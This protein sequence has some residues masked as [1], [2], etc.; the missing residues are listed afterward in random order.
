MPQEPAPE[1]EAKCDKREKDRK[2]KAESKQKR[3]NTGKTA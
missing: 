2:H 1:D 3:Q